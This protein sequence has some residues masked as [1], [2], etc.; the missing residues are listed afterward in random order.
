ML[1]YCVEFNRMFKSELFVILYNSKRQ[2]K[3]QKK[4][5]YTFINNLQSTTLFNTPTR[6]YGALN[7]IKHY[8]SWGYVLFSLKFICLNFIHEGGCEKETVYLQ[9]VISYISV[10]FTKLF[11]RQLGKLYL[12]FFLN[13]ILFP[14]SKYDS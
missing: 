9:S 5:T 12:L 8:S 10:Y 11:C 4:Y 7:I 13:F 2:I 1:Q 3:N 6:I 14:W